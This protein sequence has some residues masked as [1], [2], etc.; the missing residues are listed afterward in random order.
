MNHLARVQRERELEKIRGRRAGRGTGRVPISGPTFAQLE[1]AERVELE[2]Y[3]REA[4][5]DWRSDLIADCLRGG[6]R[7]AARFDDVL[8]PLVRRHGP[9]WFRRDL[10]VPW[11]SRSGS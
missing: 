5:R 11:E 4:G 1:L 10:R 9:R 7:R 6:T 2:R 8:C 3:A